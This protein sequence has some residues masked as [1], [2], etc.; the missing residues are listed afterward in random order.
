M[1][2][3]SSWQST[4]GV[5]G[6][7]LLLLAAGTGLVHR[8]VTGLGEVTAVSAQFI[9]TQPEPPTAQLI[10][11]YHESDGL[12]MYAPD[13]WQ[14]MARVRD[15][16]GT[17]MTYLRRMSGNAHVL[18]LPTS[19]PV[20]E[21]SAMAARLAA[22]PE[23]AYA[24]PDRLM[25]PALVP[26]D[27]QY[28]NQWH[29]FEP[30]GI[31]L[32]SAWDVTTGSASVRIAVIDTGITDHADLA[33]RWVGGYDFVTDVEWA[34]DGNG[35]DSDPHDPG[36]W[37]SGSECYPG[38]APR[39]S[40]WHGTH[41]AGTVGAIG[42]NGGGGAGINWVSP[43]V[44]VRVVGK[45]GGFISDIADGMRWAAG[46]AV[47]GV[48]SNPFPAKVLNV[49]L[50]GPG[51]CSETYQNAINA[52]N[53]TGTIIVVAAGNTDSNLNTSTYQ[54]ANCNGVLTVA[55]TDRGGDKALYSNYGA[56]VKISAPGGENI[57]VLQNGVLSTSNSGL[58]TPASDSY[59]YSQ[60]TSMAAPHVSGV[61]SLM[62]SLDPTLNLTE[63][64][65]ILQDTARPFP[66]GSSCTTL[67]CG[68]G[69]VDAMAA[70]SPFPTPTPTPS[71]TATPTASATATHTPTFTPSAT[72]TASSTATNTATF[73]A[74]AISTASSTMTQTPSATP[75]STPAA[76]TTATPTVTPTN[77]PSP[78]PSPTSTAAATPTSSPTGTSS[79]IPSATA[80]DV[81]TKTSTPFPQV[82]AT[83]ES[84][85]TSS[86]FYIF[87][88]L[89]V[90]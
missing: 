5:L 68:S 29:Y 25:F 34:N 69:I 13:S 65:A 7:L 8:P 72:L 71:T 21:V 89:V 26:N 84:P 54:P 78:T 44:P 60:G 55:A 14:Q 77:T 28:G 80:T 9:S 43:I 87:L 1:R 37:A 31:N 85:P 56:V 58:T 30:N 70:L 57:P 16:A 47:S 75:T 12:S 48:P 81:V 86:E 49:S 90:N 15:A 11:K 3:G 73:T 36:D 83:P 33:G 62:V 50:N 41:V 19:R 74:T 79:P 35:R 23:V 64:V 10:I 46:L 88:P 76:S 32:P 24:E 27:P 59:S 38:S 82:T 61:V 42:N 63:T 67:I 4:L 17:E 66:P 40:T 6:V 39:N 20:A 45:C 22:L 53:G 2:T 52:I 18:R 51:V